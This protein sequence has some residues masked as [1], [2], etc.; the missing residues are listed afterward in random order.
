MMDLAG[1]TQVLEYLDP[2]TWGR[3][4]TQR[5]F[6]NRDCSRHTLIDADMYPALI[7]MRFRLCVAGS[8][9]EY[10]RRSDDVYLHRLV[11]R[12]YMAQPSGKHCLVDH[13]NG[14]GLDN[15]SANLRWVTH[16]QNRIEEGKWWLNFHPTED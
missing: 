15:R 7:K 9:R 11:L 3:P 1:G 12:E 8:G 10:A 16:R 6:L 4:D 5:I 13:I 14:D 2:T